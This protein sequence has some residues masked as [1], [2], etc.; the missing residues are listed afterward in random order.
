M[1]SFMIRQS[2]DREP[3]KLESYFEDDLLCQKLARTKSGKVGDVLDLPW[4]VPVLGSG[5]LQ[6]AGSHSIDTEDLL[7]R[8]RERL[9]DGIHSGVL[10]EPPHDSDSWQTIASTLTKSL[11]GS[12][13][14]G[15]RAPEG[16]VSKQ[17]EVPLETAMLVLVTALCTR[18]C[19]LVRA[20]GPQALDRS[21]DEAVILEAEEDRAVGYRV[22]EAIVEPL[23]RRRTGLIATTLRL[24]E[25]ELDTKPLQ[26][27]LTHLTN[28]LN[29]DCPAVSLNTL[30][31]LT[32]ATWM[33]LVRDVATYYGWSELQL[34][35]LLTANRLSN[36]GERAKPG[37]VVRR[38]HQALKSDDVESI[39]AAFE[40]PTVQS[41]LHGESS[42][43][44]RSLAQ[45]LSNQAAWASKVK[46]GASGAGAYSLPRAIAVSV[47]FDLEL[48][49]ALAR[50]SQPYQLA[51]PFYAVKTNRREADLIWMCAT[52]D[53]FTHGIAGLRSPT[54][55]FPMTRVNK[56][57]LRS[58]LPLVMRATG[59][60]LV[61][62]E[63]DLVEESK[64]LLRDNPE[65]SFSQADIDH[66]EL[67]HAPTVD[68]YLALRQSEVEVYH[69]VIG[70]YSNDPNVTDVSLPFESANSRNDAYFAF[71]GVPFADPAVRQRLLSL[72]TTRWVSNVGD[73]RSESRS[74]RHA[75]GSEAAVDPAEL[76]RLKKER[77]RRGR[78]A[79][80][81]DEGEPPETDYGG[82]SHSGEEANLGDVAMEEP[83][84]PAAVQGIA[85]NSRLDPD[86]A[87][88]LASLGLQ[89]IHGHCDDF[90]IHLGDYAR[91]LDGEFNF[92]AEGSCEHQSAGIMERQ[93]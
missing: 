76:Q 65:Y 80:R 71:L 87:A 38:P 46:V 57:R 86:E 12:R 88:L 3:T 58:D 1:P 74:L 81:K 33:Q 93:A 29:Q 6:T 53:D 59:C 25:S 69:T 85:V 4:V 2:E 66:L 52:V 37:S 11:I 47:S 64:V 16:A 54:G 90:A 9:T 28:G 49:I 30:R 77:R 73:R 39:I 68:E 42:E 5:V 61:H 8:L 41:W 83:E 92:L 22:E 19:H 44:H 55:W 15:E 62:I 60:P 56:G 63:Q 45:L 82:D 34:S 35:L 23:T 89:V 7:S 21:S 10:I 75:G 26:N 27:L 32:E 13:T 24:I 51:V 43:T 67:R 48:E 50:Q 70:R 84:L 72:L 40:E 14:E 31:L 17:V 79:F 18:F 36:V 78:E 91:H 20:T